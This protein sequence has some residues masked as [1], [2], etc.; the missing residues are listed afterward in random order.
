MC[1][2]VCVRQNNGNTRKF[3]TNSFPYGFLIAALPWNPASYIFWGTWVLEM[4]IKLG[5]NLRSCIL[6]ILPN[7][8][9]KSPTVP[10]RQLSLSSWVFIQWE[11]FSF[12]LKCCHYF[13]DYSLLDLIILQFCYTSENLT[14]TNNLCSFKVC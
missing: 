11:G 6:M 5:C 2:C 14:N 4:V 13:R 10:I 8:P 9:R 7:N 12:F 3:E 1:V